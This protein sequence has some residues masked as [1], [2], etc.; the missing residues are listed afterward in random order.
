ML[1]WSAVRDENQ[2][3]ELN[4]RNVFGGRGLIDEDRTVFLSGG[5]TAGADSGAVRQFHQLLNT[6]TGSNAIAGEGT[7]PVFANARRDFGAAT[8]PDG[9]MV[10]VG[11]RNGAGRA[12]NGTGR[13]DDGAG[14]RREEASRRTGGHRVGAI[15][16]GALR[17]IARG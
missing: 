7:L 2:D 6:V 3:F 8:L 1:N 10:I 5:T 13:H 12:R 15:A 14:G 17:D 16:R 11:G 4:T 9:R